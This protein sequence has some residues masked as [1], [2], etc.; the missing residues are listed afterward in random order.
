MKNKH[1]VFSKALR[2]LE[3]EEYSCNALAFSVSKDANSPDRK[4][5]IAKYR[6][7]YGFG[8]AHAGYVPDLFLI[9]VDDDDGKV[10]DPFGLRILLLGFAEQVWND[11]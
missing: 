4:Y 8:D 6:Y 2:I 3:A 5:A 7:I 1:R 11:V 9:A 10:K